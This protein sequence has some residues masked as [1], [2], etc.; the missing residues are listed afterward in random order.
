MLV[1]TRCSGNRV[2][3]TTPDG[4]EIVVTVLAVTD[5]GVRLGFNAPDSVV[6]DREEIHEAKQAEYR[7][8]RPRR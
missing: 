4:T 6:I 1:L 2:I 3:I 5:W 7:N 8:G